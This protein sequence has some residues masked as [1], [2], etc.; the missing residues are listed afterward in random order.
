MIRSLGIVAALLLLWTTQA[1]AQDVEVR[2]SV[3]ETTVG[4]EEQLVYSLEVQGASLADVQTPEAPQVAG[5]VLVQRTPSTQRNMSIVNG[6]IRQSITFRWTFRPVREG[7]ASIESTDVRVAERTYTTDPIRIDVVS[8]SQRPNRRSS[9]QQWPFVVPS[10]PKAEADDTDAGGNA[11]RDLFIRAI[12]SSTTAMQNEQVTIEYRLFFR[13]GIQLRHSRLAGSWDAGGVWREEFNV[14]SRPVPSNVVEN[15]VLYHTIV[16][17]RVAVFPTRSGTITIDPLEIETEAYLPSGSSDPFERFF[18]MRGRFDT[19]DLASEAVRLRVEPLPSNAPPSFSGTVGSFDL[20]SHMD[21]TEVEVGEPV[22]VTVTVQGTG[23]IATLDAPHFDPPGVFDWYEPEVESSIDRDGRQIRGQKTFQYVLVPRSNGTFE[24]PPVSLTYFDPDRGSYVT[25]EAPLPSIRVTGSSEM[26]TSGTTIA[27][28]PIDDIATIMTAAESWRTTE[29]RPLY[30]QP[31]PYA[32]LAIP[33]GL[34]LLLF[35]Y[36]RRADR[37][38]NDMGFARS[39]MAHPLARK[40]LREAQKLLSDD[41]PREFYKEIERA[42]SGFIGNRLNIPGTGL[43]REQ[44][45]NHL[46]EVSVA[47]E[48]RRLLRRLLDECDQARFAP[49]LPDREAM[50]SAR[51]RAAYLIVAVDGAFETHQSESATA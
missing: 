18:S 49:V 16:L 46:A 14:E 44:L 42:V 6:V 5:L 9:R 3:D 11:S 12:P 20:R 41:L 39:R 33:A 23:N 30:R 40:H 31:W 36:Q 4:A 7:T 8:Q 27:G 19:I 21:D 25:S 32:A 24:I 34:L 22:Q 37:L 48:D 29:E 35:G 1:F 47:V 26:P 51:E 15:G 2:A 50:E 17:K 13:D 10:R 38:A 43:T 28:L 45:D